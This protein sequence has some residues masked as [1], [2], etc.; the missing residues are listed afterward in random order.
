VGK[1]RKRQ[2]EIYEVVD[3]SPGLAFLNDGSPQVEVRTA[4]VSGQVTQWQIDDDN[5]RNSRLIVGDK[6]HVHGHWLPARCVLQSSQFRFVVDV[7]LVQHSTPRKTE[8]DL[9][10][11]A[12]AAAAN[13]LRSLARPVAWT[14]LLVEPDGNRVLH[15]SQHTDRHSLRV[16]QVTVLPLLQRVGR[17]GQHAIDRS[18]LVAPGELLRVVLDQVQ[19]HGVLSP[20][21]AGRRSDAGV[22]QARELPVRS[23]RAPDRRMAV[24]RALLTRV[25]DVH[26]AAPQGSKTLAVMQ[27]LD[28]GERKAQWLVRQSQVQLRWGLAHQRSKQSRPRNKQ[29]DK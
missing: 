6:V 10:Q 21:P 27:S 1:S 11:F 13:N 8:R 25:R 20:A 5:P 22:L 9:Q 24:T 12:D 16:T 3:W 29:G 18:V 23:G 14:R 15:A 7:D 17:R 26:Q 19:F 4:V 2:R 28:C